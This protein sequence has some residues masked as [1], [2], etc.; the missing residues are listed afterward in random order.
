MKPRR[1][2]RLLVDIPVELRGERRHAG[3]VRDLSLNGLRVRLAASH[4]TVGERVGVSLRIPGLEGLDFA[5]EVRW[6]KRHEIGLG[7]DAGLE[8]DHTAESRRKVQAILWE[9]QSGALH[10][11]ERRSRTRA[12][13]LT[14]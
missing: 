3:S 5:A 4:V 14:G 13:G 11:V 8:F 12:K 9:V 2:M 6:A 1:D 7:C 10:D